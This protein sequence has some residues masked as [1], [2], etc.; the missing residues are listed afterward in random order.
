MAFVR[1]G[2]EACASAPAE[3]RL[4]PLLR[5]AWRQ[6]V[7]ATAG[8]QQQKPC[9][10]RSAAV[11]AEKS[12]YPRTE[13]C[14]RVFVPAWC[15][16]AVARL[17]QVHQPRPGLRRLPADTPA[18]THGHPGTPTRLPCQA[19]PGGPGRTRSRHRQAGKWDRREQGRRRSHD[20]AKAGRR[21]TNPVSRK[22]GQ[23]RRQAV[24]GPLTARPVLLGWV[25]GARVQSLGWDLQYLR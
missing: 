22:P 1:I 21:A 9:S 8:A 19:P 2:I 12:A 24:R 10:K 7:R 11:S 20:R 6:H 23:R 25:G 5:C 16:S 4:D 14:V 15:L 13:C 3:E 17:L 18:D